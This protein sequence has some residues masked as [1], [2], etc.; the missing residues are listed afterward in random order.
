MLSLPEQLLLLALDD[1]TGSDGCG[2]YLDRGLIA[3]ALVDLVLRGRI[4]RREP[5]AYEGELLLE[6]RAIPNGISSFWLHQPTYYLADTTPTGSAYLDHVLT[7]LLEH[8]KSNRLHTF[9]TLTLVYLDRVEHVDRTVY[10]GID[11]PPPD[12]R[13]LAAHDLLA[14]ERLVAT[15]SRFLFGRRTN[16]PQGN[17]ATGEQELREV[18]QQGFLTRF[19]Q[20]DERMR[21]LLLLIDATG[22]N[23]KVWGKENVDAAAWRIR[24]ALSSTSQ[25]RCLI[26]DAFFY[27]RRGLDE[28]TLDPLRVHAVIPR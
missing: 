17:R 7:T 2:A 12:Q 9:V 8:R 15:E 13:Q 25:T 4:T 26:W 5:G 20:T 3:A 10:V 14:G 6:G 18:L 19:V 27:T 28:E 23:A 1:K 16:L 11:Q 21:A 24:Q 22:L